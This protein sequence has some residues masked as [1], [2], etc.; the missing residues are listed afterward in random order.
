MPNVN[1]VKNMVAGEHVATGSS[2]NLGVSNN[3][4]VNP[5]K[6]CPTTANKGSG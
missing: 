2:V 5:P 1:A 4:V 3:N 6:E